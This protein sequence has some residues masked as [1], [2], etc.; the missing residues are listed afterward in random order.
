MAAQGKQKFGSEQILRRAAGLTGGRGAGPTRGSL[1]GG[2][3]EDREA[4]V[5]VHKYIGG[6]L[7]REQFCPLDKR[8]KTSC[9]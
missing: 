4:M 8:I 3:N 1:F 5:A 6:E 9:K 2:A 7:F